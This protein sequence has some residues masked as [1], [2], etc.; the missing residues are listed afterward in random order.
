[1]TYHQWIV[2][3]AVPLPR[4]SCLPQSDLSTAVDK[5]IMGTASV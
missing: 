5:K 3:M 2:G 4:C 1:V